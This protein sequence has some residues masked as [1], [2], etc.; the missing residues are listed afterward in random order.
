VPVRVYGQNIFGESFREYTRM[1]SVNAY[2]GSLALAARVQKGQT[3][4]LENRNSREAQEFRVAHV[5]QLQDGKWT[6]GIEFVHAAANFWQI[7]FPPVTS[8]PN[9]IS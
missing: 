9:H 2:G 7:Y 1:L 8:K 5:G 3:I 4:L 6:V